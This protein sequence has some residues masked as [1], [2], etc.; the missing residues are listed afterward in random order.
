MGF[1]DGGGS[2]WGCDVGDKTKFCYQLDEEVI[3]M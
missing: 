3:E 1:Q 2:G